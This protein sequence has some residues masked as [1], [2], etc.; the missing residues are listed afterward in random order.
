MIQKNADVVD[1]QDHL[2]NLI[3]YEDPIEEKVPFII[4]KIDSNYVVCDTSLPFKSEGGQPQF[5]Y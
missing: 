2:S 5:S 3:V 4:V 1:D